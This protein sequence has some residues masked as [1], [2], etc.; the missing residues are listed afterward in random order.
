[1]SKRKRTGELRR[2]RCRVC[3]EVLDNQ[4]Y[5]KHLESH[6]GE[7][8]SDRRET[9]QGKLFCGVMVKWWSPGSPSWSIITTPDG[10]SPRPG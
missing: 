1:M 2:V 10:S 5:P 9:G 4:S 3:R 7:D 8:P 6:P